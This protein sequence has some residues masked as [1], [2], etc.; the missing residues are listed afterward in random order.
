MD[1]PVPKISQKDDDRQ[2]E[3]PRIR[4]I[5][6]WDQ[7]KQRSFESISNNFEPGAATISFLYKY[8]CMNELSFKKPKQNLPCNTL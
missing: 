8:R 2:E 4:R 7:D 6:W 3:Q 5:A 1:S